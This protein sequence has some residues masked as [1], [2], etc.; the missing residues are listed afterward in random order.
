MAMTR[1]QLLMGLLA[2]GSWCGAGLL[3]A[4]GQPDPTPRRAGGV[5]SA[6]MTPVGPTPGDL[7]TPTAMPTALG[8]VVFPTAPTGPYPQS[9]IR[10]PEVLSSPLPYSTPRPEDPLRITISPARVGDPRLSTRLSTLAIIGTVT[11]IQ[12]ARWTTPDGRRPANPRD[13]Q[14]PYEIITPIFLRVDRVIVGAG[15]SVRL[16][17]IIPE[18]AVGEDYVRYSDGIY[19]FQAAQQVVLFLKPAKRPPL[20]LDGLPTW[21]IV[22][23]YTVTPT[24]QATNPYQTLPLAELVNIVTSVGGSASPTPNTAQSIEFLLFAS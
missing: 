17:A 20:Q 9:G 19:S 11:E 10:T 3:I 6:S 16:A 4:C 18:G 8:T 12:S 5:G 13:R 15:P 7:P 24:Q 14:S 2:G 1:R 23:R 21:D 22:D